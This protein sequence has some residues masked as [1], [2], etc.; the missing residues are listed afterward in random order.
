MRIELHIHVLLFTFDDNVHTRYTSLY[1]QRYNVYA[2][3]YVFQAKVPYLNV[4]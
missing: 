4:M 3:L 1:S 2:V